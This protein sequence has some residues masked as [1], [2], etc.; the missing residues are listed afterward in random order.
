MIAKEDD[1]SWS[2]IDL[3]DPNPNPDPPDSPNPLQAQISLNSLSGHLAPKALHLVGFISDHRVTVLIDGGST[4]NFVQPQVVTSLS[5]PC[6]TI[7]TPLRVMVGNGQY[8][9][10]ASVCEDVL[11]CI[12]NN[13]FTL[14]LYILPISGA[15]VILGINWLNLEGNM[16][17]ARVLTQHQFHRLYRHQP[18]ASYF[19]ITLVPETPTAATTHKLPPEIQHL[20]ASY[21]FLFQHPQSLPLP[22]TTDHH[23]HLLPH[24]L[25][26]NVLPYRYPHYQKHEIELQVDSMLQQGLIQPSTSL[27]SS[28]VLLVQ[29]PDGTCRFCVDYRALNVVTVKDRFPIPI[30]DELLDELGGATCFS[31]L[32]LLQGY[33]QIRMNEADVP[34]TAFRTHHGHYE[35]RVMPFGLCNAPS[36]FQTTMNMI[37]RP[38]LRHFIIV[39]FDDILIYSTSL[40]DHLLHLQTAFQILLDNQFALKLSKCF[41]AQPQVEYLGH[42]V[43]GRGV[44]PVASKVTAIHQWPTPRS[45]RAVRSFL[46]LA[47]FYR[48]FI[49]GYATI[50]APLVAV[51]TVEPFKW[52]T[53]AQMA[54]E[55]LKQALASA[56]V[57]ALPKFE[58]P[59]TVETDA[60]RV[61]M[62]AILSQQ[63]HP[64][65]FFSKP[66][67]QKLLWSS[68]YVRELCAITTAVKK[69]RQYLLGHHFI[70]LT[71]HRSLKELLTQTIQTPKQHMY[72]ARLMGY[73]YEIHYRS[74]SHNQAAD[75]LSRLPEIASSLS[76]ILSVPTLTFLEE[77]RKPLEANSEYTALRQSIRDKPQDHPQFSLSQNLVL[78]SGRIWLPRG[79]PLIN[80]LLT[81]YHA[82]P[83]GGHAGVTKTL[84]SILEN[85][86]WPGLRDD[87]KQFVAKCVDCQVTKYE[88]RKIA[89]LLC[90]LPVPNRPWE[91][92]SL[93]FIV[94]LPP[95]QGNTTILVV[96]DRFS[97]GIHLGMLPATH[98]AHMTASLF[99][100]IVVKIHGIPRSLVSDRDPLFISRFWQDLFHA[101]GT[102]L[103]MSSPYHPKTDG[104]IEVLN[105]V[106]EQYLRAFV[107]RPSFWG[108]LLPWVEWSHNTSW[109]VGTGATPYEV[110][111]GRKPFNFAEYI[112]GSSKVDAVEEMMIDRD[113][114]FQAIR[115]KLFK[116]QAAM[117]S[118]ADNKRRAVNYQMG[119]WVLLKLRPRWQVTARGAQALTGKLA[120]RFYGPFQVV[121][122][123]GPVA[124]KLQLPEGVQIH[125]IFHCSKLKPFRGSS[126]NMVGI[127]LPIELLHD[128][129]LVFPLAILDTRRA[130]N[131]DTW[132][133]LVQWNG[134]SPDDTTWE[135][136]EQL[137]HNY[138]LEDKVVFQGPRDYTNAQT[139][140]QAGGTREEREVQACNELIHSSFSSSLF[141]FFFPLLA[142]GAGSSKTRGG[143]YNIKTGPGCLI[144]LMKFDMGG[145][146]AVFGAA[147]A[148]GQIKPLG[149][150][151]HFI[152]AACENMISGTGMRPGDIVTAS[153]GKTIEVNN[154]DAEGR[155]TLADALV[156]AC[157]QGAEKIVDLAT[158][159]GAC[160]I[161][162]GSSI[163]GVFTPSDDLAKEVFDASEASG[164]KLWRLPLE[165]SYWESMKSGVADMVNTGGRPGSAITAALFLKQFVDEK[166]QWMHIDMAGPVWNEKQRCATGFGVATLVEWVLRNAS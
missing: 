32:D 123:I 43:L 60:S 117:K 77:L 46:G 84:A 150:E 65:A 143:G 140:A 89:G 158:L 95:Y 99:I 23:I 61:G 28:P 114:T 56:P 145:S 73:D 101:S 36:S 62:G 120:K 136:W 19:H 96:V 151:V 68:T 122:R 47:G 165:E 112:S 130:S 41:F 156:Y 139:E 8:L 138:H 44:E 141:L 10:C 57:L 149:V 153:N 87:V 5:L 131:G 93:D 80:T 162:L 119:D 35:F 34:K 74:G 31:K 110:T 160:I 25:P 116:A 14:D 55:Q 54:I 50:A 69:W 103:R 48:R 102:L 72:L 98:T 64:I 133:V 147:K 79:I 30:I 1:P 3:G 109:N 49:R 166:V 118:Q 148:L 126:E 100:N 161:G 52:T 142:G 4:H 71:D 81:E 76:L 154:T 124:Y 42:L 152:V 94:G 21:E 15:N 113:T 40:E 164:E 13:T 16:R 59:F 107:H 108:N 66:F 88:A 137:C 125:P 26:V 51:T 22:R 53:Q 6:Q 39:F 134:L 90:P 144:E 135:D 82:T 159:T 163:A 12:Q 104:Q 155:L 83:T 45:T 111:F 127:P 24:S 18:I 11:V 78:H 17:P 115:S 91:D 129:P 9:E 2:N 85:F 105:R 106:I 132:E 75:A 70:I 63:G 33:H 97:K 128:Q 20:L 38:Y 27:F 7:S 157:N 67:S 121:E 37:F 86:Q 146:A 58:L 92:L 29:K